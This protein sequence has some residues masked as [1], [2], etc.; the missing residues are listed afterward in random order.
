MQW[1]AY[2]HSRLTRLSE[3]TLENSHHQPCRPSQ[4]WS[5]YYALWTQ[6][7]QIISR[8][9][10]RVCTWP[11]QVS[12]NLGTAAAPGR[13]LTGVVT[14]TCFTCSKSPAT[15]AKETS[16]CVASV[17]LVMRGFYQSIFGCLERTW[18]FHSHSHG[19]LCQSC[20]FNP[21]KRDGSWCSDIQMSRP[22]YWG[23]PPES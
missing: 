21:P 23:F 20:D 1:A 5:H 18:I 7:S 17:L 8:P 15:T 19:L 6:V 13:S 16:S 22:P 2:T 3:E 12:Q 11:R 14:V 4:E 9:S 10:V